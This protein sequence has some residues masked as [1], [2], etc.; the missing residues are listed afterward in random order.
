MKR[1]DG[2]K[3]GVCGACGGPHDQAHTDL[4]P[5]CEDKRTICPGFGCGPLPWYGSEQSNSVNRLRGVARRR[6][7]SNR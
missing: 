1:P 4:C 3:M 7:Q 6:R 5:D 2:R